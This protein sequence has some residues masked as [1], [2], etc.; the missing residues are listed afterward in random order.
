MRV[1]Q[2]WL[3]SLPVWCILLDKCASSDMLPASPR[4]WLGP[5]RLHRGC[6]SSPR[7]VRARA[8]H[9]KHLSRL[10]VQAERQRRRQTVETALVRLWPSAALSALLHWQDGEAIRRR[11]HL[12]PDHPGCVRRPWAA[13]SQCAARVHVLREDRRTDAV[14]HRADAGNDAHLDWCHL[15]RRRGLWA[16]PQTIG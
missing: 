2:M 14:S 16:V 12:V 11:L 5:S 4:P 1:L 6:W 15:H 8:T 13:I 9:S 3:K 7:T 10:P